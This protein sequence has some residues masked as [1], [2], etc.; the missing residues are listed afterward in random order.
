MEE[1]TMASR[2]LVSQRPTCAL[3]GALAVCA[4]ACGAPGGATPTPRRAFGAVLDDPVVTNAPLR[5]RGDLPRSVNLREDMPNMRSQGG[6]GSCTAFSTA[7]GALGYE[8]K[9]PLLF[10]QGEEDAHTVTSEVETYASQVL[11]PK[12]T[13]ETV[14][15]AGH[16]AFFLLRETQLP[17]LGPRSHAS[18]SPATNLHAFSM[19]TATECVTHAHTSKVA[20]RI[21]VPAARACI[22]STRRRSSPATTCFCDRRQG[23]SLPRLR[24]QLLR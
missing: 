10:I 24:R 8:F 15:D 22:R 6:I 5:D 13:F 19:L 1:M 12:V 7:D 20:P 14:P 3:L 23:Q 18:R 4:S 9:V 17:P 11:A 16:L 21:L 2:T